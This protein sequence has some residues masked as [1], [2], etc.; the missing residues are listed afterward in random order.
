MTADLP[1]I[2]ASF[3]RTSVYQALGFPFHTETTLD[4][5][6]PVH[7]HGHFES[8]QH[9]PSMDYTSS[10]RHGD[11]LTLKVK[12]APNI[13][14]ASVEKVRS[15]IPGIDSAVNVDHKHYEQWAR[16]PGRKIVSS[17]LLRGIQALKA[18]MKRESME[19]EREKYEQNSK[20]LHINP[21]TRNS[22]MTR[23]KM[24]DDSSAH[25]RRERS[26][27]SRESAARSSV[28]PR[29]PLRTKSK[30]I[31]SGVFRKG[32]EDSTESDAREKTTEET[33][34][35]YSLKSRTAALKPREKCPLPVS[36]Y[37]PISI[38]EH[39]FLVNEPVKYSEFMKMKKTEYKIKKD[40]KS[41]TF[42][43]M[44]DKSGKV[45][46]LPDAKDETDGIF[47]TFQKSK[48]FSG[49]F[50]P[51]KHQKR[52]PVVD[53]RTPANVSSA[54]LFDFTQLSEFRQMFEERHIER[55]RTEYSFPSKGGRYTK[56]VPKVQ[57][58]KD[59]VKS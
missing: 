48:T 22:L 56:W 23:D 51:S 5:D 28:Q 25:F 9:F 31:D 7:H 13:S 17:S 16:V 44:P 42:I 24:S 47:E 4:K 55:S 40:P 58:L 30:T 18:R 35:T 52:T 19:Q 11:G 27:V 59:S 45:V 32:N 26:N 37:Q 36:V 53:K 8:E 34:I 38:G 2:Q 33:V 46:N 29:N 21:L 3:G 41:A 1:S 43:I 10:K 57:K 50:P 12:F 54:E 49:G 15:A 14:V 20:E 6:T 39:V